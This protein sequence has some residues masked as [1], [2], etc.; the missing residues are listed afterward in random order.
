MICRR[1]Q[2]IEASVWLAFLTAL[3]L[4]PALFAQDGVT[5][6]A[7]SVLNPGSSNGPAQTALFNDPVGLAIDAS[8]NLFIADNQNH[9]IRILTTNGQVSTFAGQAGNPGSADGVGTNA[10]FY[11]PSGLVFAPN[12][13]LYVTD[14]G[15][16]TIRAITTNGVV[17]TLAGLAG[18][19]GASNAVGNLARFDTPL[20]VTLDQNGT[21]YVADSA[22]H[23]IRLI[24]SNAV[25]TTLAGSPG[26]WG[27]SDGVG[28]NALFNC[29][30][31][32]AVDSHG[33]VFV[34]DANNH[35]IRKITPAGV[36][37]TWAGSPQ[38]DGS[39]DGTG[40][41]ALFGKPA[42]MRIDASD[43]LFVV[44]SFNHTLR[45]ITPDATV[46][47]VAGQAGAWGAVDGLGNRARFFNPY[48][49]ALDHN[50]NLR[51]SDTYNELI[52]FVYRPITAVVNA[53]P[54]A[55]SFTI[56]W[57]AVVGNSYQVQYRNTTGG[58]VWQSLGF[59]VTASNTIAA[60]IDH[61]PPPAA[62]S[63]FYRIMLVP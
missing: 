11:N 28:S 5:T 21:L 63:R 42:E 18:Q 52:R 53:G 38:A 59:P 60:Q 54:D 49:L 9:T 58:A 3:C 48:G 29:P 61:P 57:Q 32:V 10:S 33:N 26:V 2:R 41:A 39:A 50:A 16:H 23:L 31:G 56:S 14:S 25:V 47:T 46:T 17:S 44:D 1:F 45:M 36:V 55:G 19:N 51:V 37:S 24:T 34:S 12:G 62:A 4:A 15:N 20:G 43:N 27:S 40:T 22:N 6:L 30:V 35:T 7:G 13:T 8:G